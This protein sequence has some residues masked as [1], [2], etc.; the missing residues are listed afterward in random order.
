MYKIKELP[1]FNFFLLDKTHG[2]Y[3]FSAVFFILGLCF[4]TMKETTW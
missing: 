4:Q 3:E 1:Y 2:V